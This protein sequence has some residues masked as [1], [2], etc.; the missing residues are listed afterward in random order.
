MTKDR[1]LH[2]YLDLH[3]WK[4]FTFNNTLY[5]FCEICLALQ[6]TDFGQQGWRD[7]VHMHDAHVVNG[8]NMD[9]GIEGRNEW[10]GI[11]AIALNEGLRIPEDLVARRKA[12]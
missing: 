11:R 2:E 3:D 9:L 7:S 1:E 6:Y 10:I 12:E 4:T 8:K 5:R